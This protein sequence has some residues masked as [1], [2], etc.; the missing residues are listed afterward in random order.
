[1]KPF[2]NARELTRMLIESPEAR[3]CFATQLSRFAWNRHETDADEHSIDTAVAAFEGGGRSI[4]DLL[5]AITKSRSFRYRAQA[6]G[7]V[8]P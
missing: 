7:E 3:R 2:N 5:V 8:L 1:V 6:Q 4:K